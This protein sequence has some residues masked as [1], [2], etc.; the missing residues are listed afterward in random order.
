MSL[1]EAIPKSPAAPR[2]RSLCVCAWCGSTLPDPRR[3]QAAHAEMNFGMCP[4]CLSSQ[5]ARL[6]RRV[7]AG[8]AGS[9]GTAIAS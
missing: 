9:R 6:E 2:T 5:L 4:Q 7:A 1:I 8:A 3:A